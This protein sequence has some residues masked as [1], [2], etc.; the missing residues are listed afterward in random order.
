MYLGE[1]DVAGLLAEALTADAEA[2]LADETGLVGADA[3]GIPSAIVPIFSILIIAPV[4]D[5][6]STS[7]RI[8][9][10]CAFS[11][12]ARARVPDYHLRQCLYTSFFIAGGDEPD[13]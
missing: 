10:S 9:R 2:V 7:V 11:V 8:P 1:T 5:C 13:S 6:P 4:R 12:S 3:A